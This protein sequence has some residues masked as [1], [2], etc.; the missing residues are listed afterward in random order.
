[1]VLAL[2]HT[3]IESVER[4]RHSRQI[5]QWRDNMR[6]WKANE[7]PRFKDMIMNPYKK[8][9]KRKFNAYKKYIFNRVKGVMDVQSSLIK[10]KVL[11]IFCLTEF[12]IPGF[13]G[14]DE[15]E[16]APYN[17][18]LKNTGL[19]CPY[20]NYDEWSYAELTCSEFK[21]LL[22]KTFKDILDSLS[23]ND[24]QYLI[25]EQT[26]SPSRNAYKEFE[27][28]WGVRIHETITEREEIKFDY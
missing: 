24:F 3:I 15:N 12:C 4:D 2:L 26:L 10:S 5:N 23:P 16:D 17:R 21:K 27:F 6:E 11:C 14:E 19:F 9:N 25:T 13:N 8:G 18:F 28:G 1:M 7:F 22:L 20:D